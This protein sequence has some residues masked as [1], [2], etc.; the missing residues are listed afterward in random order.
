MKQSRFTDEQ[1]ID[2]LKQAD[3]GAH[4]GTFP[5]PVALTSPPS[6]SG[7]IFD[8]TGNGFLQ[9]SIIGLGW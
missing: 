6:T 1:I 7:A 3:T 5:G 9:V 4:Q 8:N 2:F